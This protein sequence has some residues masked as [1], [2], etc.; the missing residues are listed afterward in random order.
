[1]KTGKKPVSTRWVDVDKGRDGAQDVGSR[2]LAR[3]FKVR[4]G[5]REFEVFASMPPLEAKRLMFRMA[6]VRDA[7]GGDRRKGSM[8]LM[9]LDAKKAHLNGKV[10]DDEYMY[11]DFPEEAGGGPGRLRR[12]L[13]GMR[14]ATSAWEKEKSTRLGTEAGCGRGRVAPTTFNHVVSGVRLEVWGGRFHFPW[15][16]PRSQGRSWLS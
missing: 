14:P 12:W 10:K 7:V 5:G 9:L 11:V 3:D 1:V 4:G 6:A 13:Y 15:P 2:L 8:K 16:C